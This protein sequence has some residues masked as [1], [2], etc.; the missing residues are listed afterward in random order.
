MAYKTILEVTE[1]D[2][3]L[4]RLFTKQ[5]LHLKARIKFLQLIKS[6]NKISTNNLS[7]V[8]F[9]ST[10]TIQI[11]KKSYKEGGLKQLLS[12][13]KGT[14]QNK[15]AI[16]PAINALILERLS[17]P[18]NSFNSFTELHQWLQENHLPNV[19]YRIVH[20]HTKYK[21]GA[22]LKVA[23]KSHIKKDEKQVEVFKKK[24]M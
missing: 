17:S 6:N 16:T 1:S 24:L 4:N 10:R 9:V 3:D 5:P 7:A 12:F 15:G 23:R 18:T 14:N 20:H 22:S 13:A 11:W 8:L 2:S 19:T 21:L